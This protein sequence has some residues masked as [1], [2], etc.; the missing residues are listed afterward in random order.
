VLQHYLEEKETCHQPMRRFITIAERAGR[1]KSSPVF[2]NQFR[3]QGVDRIGGFVLD[4]MS[5]IGHDMGRRARLNFLDKGTYPRQIRLQGRVLR[6]KNTAEAA[7]K[8]PQTVR[9]DRCPG[10][11]A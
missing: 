9:Q 6:A 3:Q 5:G 10:D 4:P 7:G 2:P 1:Q 8:V 11:S